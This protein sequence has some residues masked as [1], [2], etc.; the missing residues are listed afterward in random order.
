L[1]RA[2]VSERVNS[3]WE[4]HQ[5]FTSLEFLFREVLM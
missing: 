2:M 1:V 5:N 4:L 3:R